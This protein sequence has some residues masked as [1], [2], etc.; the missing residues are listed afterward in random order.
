MALQQPGLDDL[1]LE[2]VGELLQIL[3]HIRILLQIFLMPVLDHLI[4]AGL[5]DVLVVGVH[6]SFGLVHEVGHD[7]VEQLLIEVGVGIVKLGLADLG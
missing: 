5:T 1:L 3:I 2:L 7:L 4:P 6:G